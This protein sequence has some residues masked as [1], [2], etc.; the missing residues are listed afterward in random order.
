METNYKQQ[1]KDFL[2]K[3]NLTLNIRQ[4][5]PQK[6]PLWQKGNE[7]HGVNYYCTLSNKD[8]KHYAF[9]FWG[10]IKDKENDFRGFAKAPTVYDILACLDT[11]NDGYT[12]EDFCT[13]YGYDTDSITAE[14]TYKAVQYQTEKLKEIL[15][16][17]QQDELNEI[18]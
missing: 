1:A 18:N 11:Y 2:T 16:K 8:G 4:A 17:E 10:S 14:K 5:V 12:F 6:A 15:T 13:Y 7:N 9:D 3:N